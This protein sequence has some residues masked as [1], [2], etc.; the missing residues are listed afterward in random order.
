MLK[1]WFYFLILLG[2]EN[3]HAQR[4]YHSSSV[5]A[6]GNWF[7]IATKEAGVYKLDLAALQSLGLNPANLVSSSIRLYGNG[8]QMLPENCSGSYTD[9]LREVAIDVSD[10]GDGVFNGA[11]YFLFYAGGPGNWKKDSLNKRFRHEKNLYSDRSFYYI[12]V[13]GTGKRVT[14]LQ[15]TAAPASAVT[16]YDE[17]Y[18]HEKDSVNFLSSG[19]S[20]YGE[21]FTNGQGRTLTHTFQVPLKNLVNAA[22]V[23][24]VSNCLARSVGS[25]SHMVVTVNNR[26]VLQ[27]NFSAV[28]S[29]NQERYAVV[30]SAT[31]SFNA[32]AGFALNY[33]YRGA[34]VGATAWLN[35]FELFARRDLSMAG[36]TQLAFRDWNSVNPG[37]AC[38]FVL[39]AASTSTRV[40]DITDFA[41]VE[42]KTDL[43]GSV[44]KFVNEC[45]RLNEYIAFEN[46]GFLTPGLIGKTGNQDLHGSITPELLIVTAAP[47]IEQ[48]NRLAAYHAQKDRLRVAVVT[49]AQVYNEFSSGSPDP[50]AIR[51]F[52]KMYYDRAGND[53][54]QRPRY[55][56]LFGDASYNYRDL[57]AGSTNLVPAYQSGSSLDPLSTYTSDDY[58][59]FLDDDENINDDS[60]I[61]LLD[62]GIGRVPAKNNLEASYFVDKVISYGD[63]ASLGQ[64][65]NRL[66][67]VAD[68]EDLN[69][70][71]QDAEIITQTAS[72]TNPA[73]I[74][75][76]IYL[77]AF[78][79]QS[80]A[81]GSR[82]PAVNEAISNDIEKG[83]LIW[84]YSG[85]G[86]FRRLADEVVLD[87]DIVNSWRNFSRLPLFITATC[88]FAPYDNP[89]INSLG[90]N[91]LLRPK[92]G[93]IALMTTTRLVFA[94]SNRLMN[95]DYLLTALQPKPDGGYL[96]LGDAVKIAK[97]ITNRS[98]GDIVNNLKF[99]LLGDPALTLAFPR[100]RVQTNSI[101]GNAVAPLP[102]TLKALKR[103]TVGGSITDHNGNV[104]TDFNGTVYPKVYDKP[105]T[106]TTLGN[107]P[108]SVKENFSVQKNVLF[109][110]NAVVKNGHFVFDFV[111][112]KDIEY[113]YG[114]GRI[115]YYASNGLTDAN[116]NFTN[117]V[118]GGSEGT[119]ADR[120]GPEIKA[121]LDDPGFVDGGTTGQTPLL[122]ATFSDTSGINILGTRIGHDL[123]VMVDDI[124]NKEYV[125]ND[126]FE[127]GPNSYREGTVI[128]RLPFL[129][130]GLHHIKIKAWDA[131]NNSTEITIRFRVIINSSF[132]ITRL[133]S[134]PNPS[135]SQT[136]FRFEHDLETQDIS[137][138]IKI[139]TLSG[140]LVKSIQQTINTGGNRS[141][142][143]EWNGKYD[144]GYSALSGI[145]VYTLQVINARGFAVFKSGQLVRF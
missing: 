128:F 65:R 91:I 32:S 2:G 98:R 136:T 53:S 71:F 23:T 76:K 54:T 60:A 67:F 130:E 107:D 64:W 72:A 46:T 116:G 35:W 25:V 84:N 31:G 143:V 119:S 95:R 85:H 140:N 138:E 75:N 106:L 96:S 70:H 4:S 131:A 66:T 50:T 29:N 55:L 27:H 74:E 56:L 141:C 105:S 1:Y 111:V 103:Y 62:I 8:G 59:G 89:V 81:S 12:T 145:Y 40:W 68:D 123:T 16:S 102:D 11:D 28:T 36:S 47:L 58:F 41:P 80:N 104:L 135:V 93:A 87:Q 92:T 63:T 39:Q 51:D 77:D 48:A 43:S 21:E 5:L 127:A 6:K 82:Y 57:S 133:L 30:D 37:S 117:F 126:F 113:Q 90:E 79:Q 94:Y 100:H 78:R 20:W 88:D 110:G 61:N 17:R 3:L 99:T 108:G 9:D 38:E 118:I 22:P 115:S 13:G 97:N 114:N 10:G 132:S 73:F 18:A 45:A 137:V 124:T 86:G 44:L 129:E 69:L 33:S 142:D 42:M 112:P 19:K 144:K 26:E 24:V 7:Q 121:F 101:N 52:L 34:G 139:Y 83:T 120:Q 122:V 109:N 125:L 15:P 14:T 49:T 134:F